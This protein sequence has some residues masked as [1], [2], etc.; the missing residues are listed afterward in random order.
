MN[1]PIYFFDVLTAINAARTL[2][3]LADIESRGPIP[4]DGQ[5]MERIDHILYGAQALL[6]VLDGKINA[7]LEERGMCESDPLF[8]AQ[9]EENHE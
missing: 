6:T 1:A 2:L 5:K 7:G 8:R 3:D 4:C 9:E